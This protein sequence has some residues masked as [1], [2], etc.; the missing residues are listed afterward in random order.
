MVKTKKNDNNTLDVL[1]KKGTVTLKAESRESIYADGDALLKQ[2]PSD[3]E[4]TRGAV[5][6][7]DGSFIQK[8]SLIKK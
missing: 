5:E 6:Y 3:M 1:L 4:W 7:V 8:Y 2:L